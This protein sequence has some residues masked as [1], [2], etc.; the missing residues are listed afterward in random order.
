MEYINKIE[1]AGQIGSVRASEI[2][3]KTLLRLS[4]ATNYVYKGQDDMAIAETTW[5]NVSYWLPKGEDA[6]LFT[7]GLPIHITGRLRNQRYTTPDGTD[8]YTCEII[9]NTVEII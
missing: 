9:A 1:I 2:G 6:S 4:V 5:H 3:N 7:K 8:H